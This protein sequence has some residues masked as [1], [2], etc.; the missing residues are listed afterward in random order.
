[1]ILTPNVIQ[2]SAYMS[3]MHSSLDKNCKRTFWS[4]TLPTICQIHSKDVSDLHLFI[5]CFV[6]LRLL[7]HVRTSLL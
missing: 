1:M 4:G 5:L 6:A 3:Y 7:E 2:N